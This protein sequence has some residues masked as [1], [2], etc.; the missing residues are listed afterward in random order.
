[1]LKYF[2]LFFLLI[3]ISG[4]SQEPGM[5]NINTTDGL[6]SDEV[7]KSLIDSKG[8]LWFATNNGV[9]FYDGENFTTMDINDGLLENTILEIEE[10]KNGKIWFVG[11]SGSL[12]YYD[13]GVIYP[14][15]YN[16]LVQEI[17]KPEELVASGCFDPIYKNEVQFTY[18]LGRLLHIKN[19]QIQISDIFKGDSIFISKNNDQYK[20]YLLYESDSKKVLFGAAFNDTTS[21]VIKQ[22]YLNTWAEIINYNLYQEFDDR[23]IFMTRNKALVFFKNGDTEQININFTPVYTLKGVYG[24][25]WIATQKSGLMFFDDL[26]LKKS[27]KVNFLKDQYITS[28]RY[29]QNNRGWVTTLTNGVY[30]VQS[31]S[32]KNFYDLKT[33]DNHIAKIIQLDNGNYL[34]FSRGGNVFFLD[35][36][37]ENYV[38][39]VLSEINKALIYQVKKYEDDVFIATSTNLI[40]VHQNYFETENI[41]NTNKQVDIISRKNMKDFL[42][43]DSIIWLATGDGL[44][45]IPDYFKKGSRKIY[46]VSDSSKARILN[47]TKYKVPNPQA[48]YSYLLYNDLFSLKRLRYNKNEPDQIDY[49]IFKTSEEEKKLITSVNDI[50]LK[51]DILYLGTQGRGLVC[52]LNDTMI[53]INKEDGLL[54]NIINKIGFN[55]NGELILGTNKGLNFIY[56]GKHFPYQY[57]S[58]KAITSSD[59][60]RGKD[61]HDFILL[62]EEILCA[63]NKGLSLINIPAVV[64]MK[65]E[66]PVYIE[67]FRV[68]EKNIFVDTI[69]NYSLK[70]NEN[71]ISISFEALDFHDKKDVQYYYKLHGSGDEKWKKIKDTRV[72]FPL[73]TPGKYTFEI[74]AE[75][76]YGYWSENTDSISFEIKEV[77]YKTWFF[78]IGF[79]ITIFILLFFGIRYFF[80]R[81]NELLRTEKLLAEYQQQSLTRVINPHFLMNVFNSINSNL[82]NKRPGVAMAYIKD[83]GDLVKHIFNSSY[84]NKTTVKEEVELL[85]S[86]MKIEERRSPHS[87]NHIVKFHNG[88]KKHYI[89][90]LMT[91][92]FVENAIHHGFSDYK[93][94]GALLAVQFKNINDFIVCE[95]TDNGMGIEASKKLE[96]TESHRPG[97]HGIDIINERLELLN[98]NIENLKYDLII[99]E[100][101]SNNTKNILGTKVELWFPKQGTKH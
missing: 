46:P 44:Y 61:I 42:I 54:S 50:V 74:K 58:I 4:F 83:V 67:E 15:K 5:K 21:V 2:K 82:F 39:V 23:I 75:N 8:Y 1:M 12:S 70:H 45:F 90:S 80:N 79:L 71:N 73:M 14:Y 17:K 16:D 56:K 25:I 49:S 62:K 6:P 87:F 41:N 31:I 26:N 89:P 57:D 18:N 68:N 72:V 30:Y 97:K 66:F 29:D 59:G 94:K 99:R 32:V 86:Y 101:E 88:V 91:Q 27:P 11:L 35:K 77:F 84:Y 10:D 78:K 38:P 100:I 20:F 48:E 33:G 69:I 51:N 43:Q 52:I 36:T 60:L 64:S 98:R 55:D 47:L 24:G 3:A 63:T 93:E 37:Y 40:R 28:I 22:S 7:Y 95:I 85:K 53:H 13:K 19:G 96:K 81:R 65:D 34:S 76:S 92:I 9:C